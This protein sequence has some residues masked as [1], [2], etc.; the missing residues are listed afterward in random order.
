MTPCARHLFSKVVS[1][2]HLLSKLTR[3]LLSFD[4]FCFFAPDTRA[5]VHFEQDGGLERVPH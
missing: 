4:F 5:S 2:V 1:I 3:E